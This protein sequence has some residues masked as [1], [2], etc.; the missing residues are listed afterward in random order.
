M[1][2]KNQVNKMLFAT[3]ARVYLL[4][5]FWQKFLS[6]QAKDPRLAYLACIHCFA[7]CFHC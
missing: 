2:E 7:F 6:R 3:L 5:M 4:S 1:Q